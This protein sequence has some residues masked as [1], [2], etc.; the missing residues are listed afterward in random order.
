M[1]SD[2]AFTA[3]AAATT[4]PHT[5]TSMLTSK[6]LQ[7]LTKDSLER[8]GESYS[9]TIL[10]NVCSFYGLSETELLTNYDLFE[11]SLFRLLGKNRRAF[12]SN[13]K[14]R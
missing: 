10:N 5:A 11:R 6:L 2:G 14:W 7:D 12:D 8:I 13:R 4:T 3:I 1:V 9:K